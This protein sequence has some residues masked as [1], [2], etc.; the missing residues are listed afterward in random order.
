MERTQARN[1]P[2]S[3]RR[4]LAG[5]LAA[6]VLL[7]ACGAPP[8]K[9]PPAA[10][11][12]APAPTKA[13]EAKPTSAPAE[14]KPTAAPTAAAAKPAE[15]AT[16]EPTKPAAAATGP[17]P[18]PTVAVSEVGTGQK[19]ITF[20]HGL[21]GPDGA[22]MSELL[23]LYVAENKDVKVRQEV[24]VWDTFY[25]KFPT[26]VIAGTP[27]DMVISHEW[28]IAQLGQKNVLRVADD[29]YK[30]RG[31]PKEDFIKFAI[32]NTTYQ[33]KTYGVLLDNHG[34]GMYVNT[35]VFK[36]AG[37]DP[38]KPPRNQEE[39]VKIAQQVTRDKNGKHPN[40]SGFDDKNVDVWGV[41]LT[42]IRWTPLMTIWQYGGD[43]VTED[44][45]KSRLNEEPAHKALQF[46]SDAIFKHKIAPVPVGFVQRDAFANGK[47]AMMMDGSWVLNFIKDRPQLMPP[48]TKVWYTP[49]WGD[50]QRQTWMSAHVLAL[51]K[52]SA[53]DRVDLATNLLVWLSNNSIKWT[54]GSGQPPAR[55]SLQNSEELQKSWHTSVFAK[56]FQ[57]MGRVER[58]HVN[59]VE[60][61]AAYQPEFN[62][63]LTNTKSVKDALND[64][65]N[66]VQR[67][68]DRA[69]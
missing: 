15:K 17:T 19:Q 63:I 34:Y 36:K 18:T 43:T 5:S 38:E 69:G 27:P 52:G 64:A 46:W 67:I 7:V 1:S 3:R 59:I 44:G 2:V 57:E 62:A 21:T 11:T 13:P 50:K 9:E 16:P 61:Q 37:V 23:K 41:S 32:E 53:G 22:T 65:H 55:I 60:I 51:P 58:Q 42:N 28:A 39:F 68:L 26:A 4:F 49:Q 45:K 20:W 14:S 12:T 24:M 56:M 40:E 8:T 47:L 29:I 10:A 66:R 54:L 6:G 33:G 31:I 35:D 48:V 30:D 25:Q